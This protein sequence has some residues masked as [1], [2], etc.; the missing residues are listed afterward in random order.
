VG[1]S[2]RRIDVHDAAKGPPQRS[3]DWHDAGAFAFS[4]DGRWLAI[5]RQNAHVE[6]LPT[7][8]GSAFTLPVHG[9]YFSTLTF[10]PDGAALAGVDDRAVAIWNLASRQELLRLT[11]HKE[12]VTSIAFSPDGSLVATTCGDAMTRIWDAHDGRPLASLPGPSYMLALAFSPD[13]AYLAAAANIG[14][15]C[16][17]QLEGRREQ[18]R[19]IG[20]QFGVDRLVFHPRLPRLASSS[21]DHTVML[22]DVDSAHALGRWSA[23]LSWVTGLTISPDG[24]LIASTRGDVGGTEDP[25]I[26][27]WDAETGVLKK[28]L[29]GNQNGVWSLAFDPSGRRIASGDSAGTVLLFEVESARV[30]RRENLGG[31]RVSSL[32]FLNEGRSL[33]VGQDHGGVSLFE[34]EQSDPPRRVSLPDGCTR[35]VVDRRGDR[36][37]V[38]D[39]KGSL[40]AL[41]LTD[42]IVVH[43][44]DDGHQGAIA[45]LALSPDGLL[46]ATVGKDR[47]VVLRDPATFKTL[48]TFPDWT[49]PLQDVAFDAT[50]RWIAFAGTDSEI[51]LWDL[52][53]IR[54]ELG[55]VGLSWDQTAPRVV[56]TANLGA[57]MEPRKSPV[58]VI[59]PGNID[60][61]EFENARALVNSGIAAF[62]Q[63]RYAVAAVDL[64]QARERL[65]AMRRLRPTDTTLARLHATS[66][67]FLGST[68]RDLKRPAEALAH[69]RASLAVYESMN[70]PQAMDRY[71]MACVCAMVSSLDHQVSPDA[72]EKLKVRAMEF[73]RSAI[74]ED[75]AAYP[76][77]F[78]E[79]HDLDP[80]RDRAEF[81]DLM[82]DV[83]FPRD[84]FDGPSPL[85]RSVPETSRAA[86]RNASLAKKNEGHELQAAGLTR[87]G[88]SVLSS[89]LASNADDTYLLI[90]V[91]ALQ[92]WFGKD[93]ELAVTC[94]R[95]LESARDKTDPTTADRTAKIC[96]LRPSSDNARIN[97][98]LA[99]ARRAVT[100][101]K[102]HVWLPYFR[103]ALG[104]AE[105]RSGNDTAADAAFLAA[106]TSSNDDAQVAVTSAF[107]RAMSLFRRG[108]EVEA[109]R[110]ATT[111]ASRMKPLPADENNPLTGGASADDLILWMAYK[112][113][114]AILGLD[115]APASP[116]QS[117]R[118]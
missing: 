79:D 18:R 67:G 42:L 62:Q 27:L 104:M 68:L 90:E 9:G 95:A 115:T 46:L 96:C 33:L 57:E 88:V 89:A 86:D 108:K 3:F 58:R 51:G 55:A 14:Q 24:S 48:L 26:R 16:L 94:R 53:L 19:L 30:L 34:L 4:P 52:G 56:R 60:P 77:L 65:Q 29:P 107:Y 105:Y 114:R 74:E 45:S 111:A 31:S 6:L 102:D 91:A 17:Y 117:N 25:S 84:P 71:N 75:Q 12:T 66:L 8:G 87:Q 83:V 59:R 7:G 5:Q 116:S 103:M 2:D 98:A 22:W 23:H 21:D 44:L 13:G 64:Q 93:A 36:V 97:A 113:A 69:Y 50:G 41:S 15:V 72:T 39:S 43:R 32:V 10:S 112:E 92:A 40:I 85:S 110:I 35:L 106:A 20:H 80:L 47:R 38:G 118:H 11:G 63:R 61:A 100:L 73:L 28:K 76:A 109:R 99:L 78:S 1:W 82:A 37:I 54:D 101:G 81:R 70:A 49:G